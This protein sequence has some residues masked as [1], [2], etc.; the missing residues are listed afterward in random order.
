MPKKVKLPKVK[1]EDTTRARK[2][3]SVDTT[4]PEL[5]LTD[6]LLSR[7]EVSKAEEVAE[8]AEEAVEEEAEEKAEVAEDSTEEEE[9]VE[10]KVE[11]KEEEIDLGLLRS[12]E[13]E[14]K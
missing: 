3:V 7:Q 9:K 11:E 6:S 4:N 10:V 8:A 1:T 5:T 13:E 12:T 14:E 2:E